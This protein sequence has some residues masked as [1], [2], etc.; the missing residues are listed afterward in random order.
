LQAA[1]ETQKVASTGAFAELAEVDPK[2]LPGKRR[3]FRGIHFRD[4]VA[5]VG[6]ARFHLFESSQLFLAPFGVLASRGPNE[7]AG[8][9]LLKMLLQG[10]AEP[11]IRGQDVLIE[12]N[13]VVELA[14]NI[15]KGQDPAPA[16]ER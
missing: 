2:L 7:D 3:Q 5:E 15:I 6:L 9:A 12:E 4:D 1:E 13:L 16:T 11:V 8:P 14:Q 10:G